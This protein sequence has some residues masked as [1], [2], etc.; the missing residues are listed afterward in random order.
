MLP[1][2][3]CRGFWLPL[4]RRQCRFTA[5]GVCKLRC[6]A[7]AGRLLCHCACD[8]QRN[9]QRTIAGHLHRTLLATP[10]A[11]FWYQY[12]GST[13]HSSLA[14]LVVVVMFVNSFASTM[15]VFFI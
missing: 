11:T 7:A 14:C 8:L 3:W 12:V 1:F 13:L 15:V 2:P 10:F 6:F 4:V 9:M 5:K